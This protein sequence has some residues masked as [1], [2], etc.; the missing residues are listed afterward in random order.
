M[1]RVVVH[2]AVV[3]KRVGPVARAATHAQVILVELAAVSTRDHR[4]GDGQ[5]VALPRR[6][7]RLCRSGQVRL[8]DNGAER[9]PVAGRLR[10]LRR[11]VERHAVDFVLQSTLCKLAI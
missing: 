11:R 10:V 1:I 8:V 6:V 4:A 9:E 2:H 7:C 3:H 5:A